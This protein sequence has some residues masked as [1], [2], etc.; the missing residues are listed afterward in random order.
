[1]CWGV[2]VG[3]VWTFLSSYLFSFFSQL[4]PPIS[5]HVYNQVQHHEYHWGETVPEVCTISP[6]L[7]DSLDLVPLHDGAEVVI[8][9]TFAFR[10]SWTCLHHME[11]LSVKLPLVLCF[12]CSFHKTLAEVAQETSMCFV[13]CA[14]LLEA[15]KLLIKHGSCWT[16]LMLCYVLFEF[17]WML[18][19]EWNRL[20]TNL[21]G[22]AFFVCVNPGWSLKESCREEACLSL[23]IKHDAFKFPIYLQ[24]TIF[25]TTNFLKMFRIQLSS[26]AVLTASLFE[27][28]TKIVLVLRC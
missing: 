12:P 8:W 27:L 21:S 9:N 20:Y 11:A 19:S 13:V 17:L 6:H 15:Q 26:S 7:Y 10:M 2:K 1:M 3:T 16:F 24:F 23:C 22:E 4:L 28:K 25:W 5:Y 18:C 14:D